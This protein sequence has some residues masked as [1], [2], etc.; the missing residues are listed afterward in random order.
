MAGT[1]Y[2]KG[3]YN[4]ICDR[5]GFKIKAS[6]AKKQW[7][8]LLVKKSVWEARHPQDFIRSKPDHQSVPDPRT[9]GNDYFL[10]ANEVSV[11]DL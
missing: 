2:K 8:G 3:D 11:D 6:Q 9:E 4:L 1:Y 5:T 7:D 10:S